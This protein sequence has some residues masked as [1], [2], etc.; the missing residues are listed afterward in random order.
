MTMKKLLLILTA[1]CLTLPALSQS[2]VIG[3]NKSVHDTKSANLNGKTFKITFGE[4]TISQNTGTADRSKENANDAAIK[5]DL[6]SDNTIDRGVKDNT[7]GNTNDQKHQQGM[8]KETMNNDNSGG[9]QD[10]SAH[11]HKAGNPHNSMNKNSGSNSGYDENN[12]RVQND[13]SSYEQTIK[14]KTAT[15]TFTDNELQSTMLSDNNYKSCPYTVS[16]SSDNM[17]SFYSNCRNEAQ[18]NSQIAGIVQ[19]NAISGSMTYTVPG[20]KMVKY[21]FKGTAVKKKKSAE[22]SSGIN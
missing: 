6:N 17:M 13:Y 16:A 19:G 2:R 5:N 15:I 9:S 1:G 18:V 7:S 8:D 22:E 20:G 11:H 3:D 12:M 4:Q 21:D 14:G 10:N